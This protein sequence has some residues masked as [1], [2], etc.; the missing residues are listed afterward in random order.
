MIF[1]QCAAAGVPSRRAAEPRQRISTSASSPRQAHE[2]VQSASTLQ[3]LGSSGRAARLSL[4]MRP[5]VGAAGPFEK[6]PAGG[7]WRRTL[8]AGKPRARTCSCGVGES[9][10]EWWC[11]RSDLDADTPTRSRSVPKG[12][13]KEVPKAGPKEHVPKEAV[14]RGSR[15]TPQAYGT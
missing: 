13:P 7:G 12:G 14:Q 5:A 2:H 10:F 9:G 1:T 4:G 3:P 8:A 15:G 6:Q 11:A